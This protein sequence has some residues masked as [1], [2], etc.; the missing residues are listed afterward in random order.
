MINQPGSPS[1]RPDVRPLKRGGRT[2]T[3]PDERTDTVDTLTCN[4]AERPD[5]RPNERPGQFDLAGRILEYERRRA[6]LA[7]D[8]AA[9]TAARAAVN[10]EPGTP[11]S[12]DALKRMR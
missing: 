3:L 5:D 12:S 9:F 2:D 6:K 8:R 7:A 1:K 4:N 11:R 10:S